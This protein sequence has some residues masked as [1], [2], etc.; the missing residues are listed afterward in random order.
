MA[1]IVL[2]TALSVAAMGPTAALPA[3]TRSTSAASTCGAAQDRPEELHGEV[4]AVSGDRI[5]IRITEEGWLPRAGRPVDIGAEM[6]GMWVPLKGN[7][8]VVQVNED[9]VVAQHV[10]GGEHRDPARGMKAIIDTSFPNPPQ[11]RADYV[12]DRET[13][14]MVLSM[15]E[16]GSREAQHVAALSF[17]GRGDHDAALQWWERASNGAT[18][19]FFISYSATGRAKIL[20]IRGRYREALGI[21]QDAATRMQPRPDEL[22]FSAY[23]ERTGADMTAAVSLYVDVLTA[24]GSIFRNNME[25]PDEANRWLREAADVMASA[26]TNGAPGPDQPTHG[27]YLALLNELGN[28]LLYALEDEAEAV[29]YLQIAAR[30]GDQSAQATLTRLGQGW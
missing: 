4:T 19:R 2:L 30:A 25:A 22:T 24:I 3:P 9:S 26:V 13:E 23:S 29:T 14:A 1:L 27:A 8:V 11:T 15:A 17:E 6:A 20:V 12:G 5:R 21:L 10:G 28:F 18:E 16:S 7:F